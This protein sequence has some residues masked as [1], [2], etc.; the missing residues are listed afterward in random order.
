MAL[1]VVSSIAVQGVD[2]LRYGLDHAFSAKSYFRERRCSS[3][4]QPRVENVTGG[5]A[6][7]I[8]GHH[9]QQDC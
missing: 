6:D 3:P 7:E 1:E 2:Q 9:R 5:V 8:E 4:V